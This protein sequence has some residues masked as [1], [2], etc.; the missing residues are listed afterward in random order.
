MNPELAALR[1]SSATLL[2]VLGLSLGGCAGGPVPPSDRP[3]RLGHLRAADSHEPILAMSAEVSGNAYLQIDYRSDGQVHSVAAP[4]P[5]ASGADPAVTESADAMRPP[6][7]AFSAGSAGPEAAR[8]VVAIRSPGDWLDLVRRLQRE[9]AEQVPNRGVVLDVLRQD[10]LFLYVDRDGELHAVPL[11]DKAGEIEPAGVVTLT[12]LLSRAAGRVERSLRREGEHGRYLLFNTGDRPDTGFPFVLMDLDAGR[13]YFIQRRSDSPAVEVQG[14]ALAAQAAFHA[15][16]SQVKGLARPV[17]SFARLLSSVGSTAVD[18]LWLPP[19]LADAPP[20]PLSGAPPMDVADWERTLGELV[21]DSATQGSI[22]YLVDGDDFFPALVHAIGQARESIRMRLYIFDNDDYAV[23]IADL[24]KARSR[25]I[26]VRVLLDGLGTIA[27]GMAAPDYTPTHARP[28]PASIAAYL[29]ADSDVAVRMVANPWMQGD[30]TKVIVVDDRVAFLGGMNIGR[31]YRYEWHDLMVRLE[32]P[33]VDILV[34]D[35]EQAWAQE[36]LF[37]DLQ[38][39]FHR[40]RHPVREAG[41]GDRPLRLLYTRPAD[42]QIL[43]SQVQAMRRARS[44]VWL[45]NAYLTSDAI[46]RELIAARRRGVDVRVILPYQTDAGLIDRSNVLAMNLLLR[47]GIRVFVYPGMS[48]VKAAVYDGWA[49]LGSANF[50]KLSLQLNKET[51]V[52]TSDPAAVQ[53]LLDRVFLPDFD[54]ALELREPLPASWLDRLKE[55]IADHL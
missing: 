12:E 32:G 51:N 7:V 45:H 28:G 5:T 41:P 48:H 33:V 22:D 49:C 8:E 42:F 55:L 31:E 30:H 3:S 17:S 14:P 43:R 40:A 36:G 27:G 50:D 52:A 16:T 47:H 35:F 21:P 6:I 25:E 2:L 18:T 38:A 10:E 37:G 9:V 24:L 1:R 54:R 44:R 15:I 29:R 39:A 13:V 46:V 11:A 53:G 34:R 23:K 20:P 4:L 19:A 26:D